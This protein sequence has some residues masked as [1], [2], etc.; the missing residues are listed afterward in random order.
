MMTLAQ[1]LSVEIGPSVP[2]SLVEDG[3]GY[4]THPAAI[5]TLGVTAKPATNNIDQRRK[6]SQRYQLRI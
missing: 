4:S 3:T 6:I 1:I 5:I 2:I